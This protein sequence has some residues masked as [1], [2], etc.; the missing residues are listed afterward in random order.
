MVFDQHHA[1]SSYRCFCELAHRMY[2]TQMY[3]HE[4]RWERGTYYMPRELQS[5]RCLFCRCRGIVSSNIMTRVEEHICTRTCPPTCNTARMPPRPTTG[6]MQEHQ[7]H[8]KDDPASV[9]IHMYVHGDVSV[10]CQWEDARPARNY[11]RVLGSVRFAFCGAGCSS[12]KFCAWRVL[13]DC[14]ARA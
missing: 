1:R 9:G 2:L 3:R 12:Y 6:L 7:G 13:G 11:I 5:H 4:R 10:G 8:V 14:G